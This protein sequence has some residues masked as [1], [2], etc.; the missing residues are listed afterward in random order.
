MADMAR[1]NPRRKAKLKA[2]HSP[3]SPIAGCTIRASRLNLVST[4]LGGY[5]VA[6]AIL[7]NIFVNY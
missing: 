2:V 4:I 5:S 7:A 3:V 6:M 1:S